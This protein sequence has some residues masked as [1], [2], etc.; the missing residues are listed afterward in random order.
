MFRSY[1]GGLADAEL[2]ADIGHRGAALHLPQRIR[3]L[4]LAEFAALHGLSFLT[5]NRETYLRSTFRCTTF[6]GRRQPLNGEFASNRMPCPFCAE[7]IAENAIVC[8]FCGCDLKT[9]KPAPTLAVHQFSQEPTERVVAEEVSLWA[10]VEWLVLGIP[11][12][13]LVLV[14][15]HLLGIWSVG[16]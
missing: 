11:A 6:L 8:R 10:R 3:D 5:G 13:V 14:L 15:F 4:L 9:S 1:K 7:L 16:E 12:V 2:A